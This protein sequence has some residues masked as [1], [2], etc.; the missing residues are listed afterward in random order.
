[1]LVSLSGGRFSLTPWRSGRVK[2]LFQLTVALLLLAQAA[3]FLAFGQERKSAPKVIL[4]VINRHFTVGRRISSLDLRV[5]SDE[6]VECHTEKYWD[7]A[8]TVRRQHA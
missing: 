7:E 1:M 3:I 8:D 5:Y 4:E 2:T 6:T